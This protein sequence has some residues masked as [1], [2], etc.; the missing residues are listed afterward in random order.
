MDIDRDTIRRL[1]R[2]SRVELSDEEAERITAELARIVA[3]VDVMRSVDTE[4]V[5]PTRVSS[6]GVF[7]RGRADEPASGLGRDQAVSQAPDRARGCFRV[8]RAITGG[9]DGDGEE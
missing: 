1:E 2:L 3:F 5:E 7:P 8:P 6:R 9:D 4:G